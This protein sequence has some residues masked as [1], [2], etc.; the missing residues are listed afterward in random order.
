MSNKYIERWVINVPLIALQYH[1]VK[2]HIEFKSAASLY[3][4]DDGAAV[5]SVP[6]TFTASLYVDYIYLDTDERRRFA[7]V[8]H[9]Y[10]IEQLQ[11]TGEETT[12]TTS[13]S[14]RLNFNH[15]CKYLVWVCQP[16][17]NV[18]T[19]V[20]EW[21]NYTDATGYGGSD[22]LSNAKLQLNG[23]D[24]FRQRNA[25]YFNLVQPYQHFTRNPAVGVYVYSF[26]LKP[27]EHQPSGSVNMSR[28]DNATLL[29]TLASA[30]STRVRIYAV[31][32][33]VLRIM[34]GM[35]GLAYSN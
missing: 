16:D 3:V 1:E 20:N 27:E 18:A 13:N 24:R 29:L 23:H 35:G 12:S 14:F 7:Q 2:I 21:T 26:A 17:A 33:N 30:V 4:T 5:D 9:E 31:N 28:I 22:P 34:S 19:N 8:S 10:L 32:Y 6:T 15:P 11:F 25:A